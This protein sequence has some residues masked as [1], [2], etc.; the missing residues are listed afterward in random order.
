MYIEFEL[1]L[2][3]NLVN[4]RGVTGPFKLSNKLPMCPD[5]DEFKLDSTTKLLRE[6]LAKA[7]ES[8]WKSIRKGK[9]KSNG[10]NTKRA[11]KS[12]FCMKLL[13]EAKRNGH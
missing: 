3:S 6:V 13:N 4:K 8:C 2:E 10:S 11:E 9:A 7:T 12:K 5:F 1:L